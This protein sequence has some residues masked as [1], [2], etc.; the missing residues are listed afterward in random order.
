MRLHPGGAAVQLSRLVEVVQHPLQPVRFLQYAAGAG[1]VGRGRGPHHLPLDHLGKSGDGVQRRAHFMRE[2]AQRVPR[3]RRAEQAGA[4][5]ALPDAGAAGG[6]AIAG[7]AAA[8]GVEARHAGNAPCPAQRPGPRDRQP[9]VAERRAA[10]ERPRG[11]AVDA[12]RLA[13]RRIRD[14]QA[15]DRRARM[16]VAPGDDAVR[17]GLEAEP[18]RL[19]RFRMQLLFAKR[20]D[21]RPQLADVGRDIAVFLLRRLIGGSL[22]RRRLLD[23]R[24]GRALDHQIGLA[25]RLQRPQRA[26][27]QVAAVAEQRAR[28]GREIGDQPAPD[29]A[30]Q[31]DPRQQRRVDRG[32]VLGEERDHVRRDRLA[33][34]RH[35]RRLPRDRR[36]IGAPRPQPLERLR[37]KLGMAATVGL[38]KQVDELT[39]HGLARGGNFRRLPQRRRE[40]VVE[41]HRTSTPS[42]RWNNA[43]RGGLTGA[44]SRRNKVRQLRLAAI[45]L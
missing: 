1:A 35:R 20:L 19:G 29:L 30:G 8:R 13:G 7:E 31:L 9:C 2:L 38:G 27:G 24:R 45:I 43:M 22:L 21:P 39:P 16:G 32:C 17:A 10:A 6:A 23:G 26:V 28:D 37:P 18:G 11:L 15:D 12:M 3:Q 44:K 5:G 40:P 41:S 25:E 36:N 34:Q 42:S 33:G 4:F 14:R